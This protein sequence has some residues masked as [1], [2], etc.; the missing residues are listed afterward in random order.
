MVNHLPGKLNI[1]LCVGAPI[2]YTGHPGTDWTPRD[3]L[4]T[5]GHTGHPG[6]DWTAWDK[7]DTLAYAG[8]PGTQVWMTDRIFGLY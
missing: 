7:H 6:T 8:H 1:V 2:L 4:D 5:L 3:R